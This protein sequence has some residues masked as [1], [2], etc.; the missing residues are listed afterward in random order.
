M[1]LTA[2]N[3]L[4]TYEI[5]CPLGAGGMGEVYRA[6]DTRLG[7]DVA[8]KVLPAAF[9]ADSERLA[10][11]EQ[12]AKCLASLNHPHI[13]CIYGVEES[14]GA[15]AIV[16]E[17]VEGPTLADR[18]R[19]GPIPIDEALPIARQIADALEYAHER[20]IIHRDLKPANIKI[21][22]DDAA[23]VLDFGL[24]KAL[25]DTPAETV[26][27][28]H[29]PTLTGMAT[30]AGIILGTAGYMSPEQARGKSV[31]R[32]A[33]I[34]SFGCVL[35]EMLTGR[36]AFR[37]ETV[38]DT[39]AAILKSEPD[40]SQLPAAT[41]AH[42]RVMLR[43]CLQKDP[44]QRLRDIGDARISLE[45]VIAGSSELFTSAGVSFPVGRRIFPWALAGLFAA[46]SAAGLIAW[47]F[48]A[49][50]SRRPMHFRAVTN[51]EGVQAEP[52]I[53]P[54]GRSV[55]F[56]S[57]RGGDFNLY[58]GLLSGGDL[59]QVTH[60]S[61][62]K[63]GPAWSPDGATLAFS[64]MNSSGTWDIWE[65]PSL[66]GTSR[67]VIQNANDAAWSP[68]GTQLAYAN[69]EDH[70]IW[71]AGASGENA[72]RITMPDGKAGNWRYT[73]PRFSPDGGKIAFSSRGNGPYGE[74]NVFDLRSGNLHAI[75]SDGALALSPVWSP[76]GRFIYFGSSR[77]GT[78]NI[79][80]IAATGGDKEQ[81]TSG[82]GDDA[83]LDLSQDGNKIVFS[84]WRQKINLTEIDLAGKPGAPSS[85]MLPMDPGRN[86]VGPSYSSD[87]KYLAYFSNLK[88][89]ERESI[90]V[91]NADG[92]NPVL[93]VRDDRVNVFPRWT[94][95]GQH[96]LYESEAEV[97][98][99]NEL[100]SVGVSGGVPQKVLGN[101]PDRYFDVGTDGRVLFRSGG[102][103][104]DAFDPRTG[105]TE[106][107]GN[108]HDD[109]RWAPI[110]WSPDQRQVAYV[111][112]S[113]KED[114][115]NAGLWVT[116][117]KSSPRQIF[118]GW[119]DWW[120]ARGPN[121]QIYFV[122]GRPDLKGELWKVGWNGGNLASTSATARMT[123]SYWVDP[124]HNSQDHFAVSPDGR[125][126]VVETQTFVEANIDLIENIR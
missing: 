41:S 80:K 71:V 10:R 45:E 7:R 55:A 104:V 40:W 34:W 94:P 74:L 101:Q 109:V 98:V 44:R 65:T 103:P 61:N 29:S 79:W 25:D 57:N 59:V 113:I 1:A 56:L 48:G 106:T 54:D 90:W 102:G 27:L 14:T 73:E 47:R 69:G 39:L 110:L 37:G 28:A 89:A 124:S 87:G 117:F 49:S 22:P 70:G 119:A 9:A 60:D 122:K 120:I 18:I 91:S 38:T 81:I 82:Q 20:G 26:D 32:R 6:R 35:F 78:M 111:V 96:V 77:G 99:P 13:A 121:E 64:R 62:L 86:Q 8:L 36:Q 5:V 116:D 2:G 108:I 107:L 31:D 67:R 15:P 50:A 63:A 51:L 97:S 100:R 115:P 43:R 30:Q 105:A 83:Q 85:R 92:S 19:K 93:L 16:M 46:L 95:D 84:T 123:Y 125:F 126:I 23:K 66:G 17:L 12:E 114:D 33:D 88:G 72:H 58:V 24:A 11:F 53:S 42:V 4:G 3:R 112:A 52:A 75:T 21:T 68:D 76:D 118:R